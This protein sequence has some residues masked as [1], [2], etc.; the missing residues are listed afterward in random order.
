M[1]IR[2]RLA[3]AGVAVAA[4]AL[5]LFGFGLDRLVAFATPQDQDRQLGA[6][7][8]RAVEALDRAAPTSLGSGVS[9]VA[10][11]VAEGTEQFVA[12]LTDDGQVLYATAR[13][14]PAL[15]AIPP[16]LLAEARRDGSAR[17]TIR[18][19]ADLELRIHVRPWK[20]PALDG[21]GVVVAGQKTDFAEEQVTNFRALLLISG[22]IAL[23]V[24]AL[25]AW[26]VSGRALRPLRRLATTADEIG[27]TGDLGRRLSPG[28][29]RDVLGMLTV[30][31]NG[32]LDRL[33][34]AQRG[35]EDALATQR[36]FVAD[37]SHELRNPLTTIRSNAGFLLERPDAV[38]GDR[39]EAL[40]DIAAEGERMA[41]V[42]DD[43]L[44]LARTDADQP[45]ERRPVALG[46]LLREAADEARRRGFAVR[47]EVDSGVAVMGDNAALR[48]LVG[49]LIDNAARHGAGDIDLRLTRDG[50]SAVLSVSDQGPG[51]PPEALE[52][53]FDRFYQADPVRSAQG[54]G[55]GLSIA[56][57]IAHA[58]GGSVAA[59]NRSEG[60][61]VLTL[62]L[63]LEPLPPPG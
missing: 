54:V 12:V 26:V 8:E 21:S 4:V 44:T 59:G 56:R 25:A 5:I 62:E 32:M 63:P 52:R 10:D 1:S 6:L 41:R 61:A 7:A 3:F 29:S 27:R 43:L 37:A 49:I 19:G 39:N 31:F 9:P 14:G 33:T 11:D 28:R 30:S 13:L 57:A 47:V 24:A 46:A 36:Q 20:R 58:H 45:L 48:R 53:I 18:S 35:L 51:I 34:T 55:L 40:A 23:L 15:D 2:I 50:S 16:D 22:A 60:G 38:E 42:V 17:A